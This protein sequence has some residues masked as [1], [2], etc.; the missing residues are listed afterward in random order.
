[1]TRRNLLRVIYGLGLA[2]Y[3]TYAAWFGFH[4]FPDFIGR[5]GMGAFPPEFLGFFAVCGLLGYLQIG[6]PLAYLPFRP[7]WWGKLVML[8]FCLSWL[9]LWPVS[10]M[11][12]RFDADQFR[13]LSFAAGLCANV[14][15]ALAIAQQVVDPSLWRPVS[16]WG[17]NYPPPRLKRVSA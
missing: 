1:M 17:G 6:A 8:L 2:T 14:M 15:F 16:Q 4:A 5:A 10:F 12:N 11:L 9:M 13:D 7:M 3:T